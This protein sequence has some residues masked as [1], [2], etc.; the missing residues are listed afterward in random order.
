MTV[1][2]TGASGFVGKSLACKLS[3]MTRPYRC[4]VRDTAVSSD[5]ETKRVSVGDI[6]ATTD[7]QLALNNIKVVI[8]LAARAHIMCDSSTDPLTEY[9]KINTDGALNLARQAAK[10]GVKRFIFISTIKVNGE[11]SSGSSAFTEKSKP[12]PRDPYAISKWDAETGLQRI[13]DETGMQLVIIRPPLVYGPGVKANFFKLMKLADSIMPLP[14]GA[15][16]NNRSMIYIGNLVDFI[17]H[18]IDHPA[19]A[20]QTFLISDNNDLSLAMLIR[21]L[22]ISL[23]RPVRLL[24]FPSCLFRVAAILTGKTDAVDKLIG[25]L[26][27]DSAKAKNLLGWTPPYSVEQGIQ[28]TVTAYSQG[29]K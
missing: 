11:T 4:A 23:E 8:H 1:L 27:I 14:F 7:W 26:Q 29:K 6:N 19:A 2:I 24:S 16:N 21:L 13:A 17:I 9:K 3:T 5:S 25:D 18:C 12:F 15:I 20:N 10:A 22:R 28:A